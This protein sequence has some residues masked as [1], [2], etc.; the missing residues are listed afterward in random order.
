M[1][2]S[3]HIQA[4]VD[5]QLA[6]M[7]DGARRDALTR[8]LVPPHAQERA[9][10][11]GAP[12]ERYPYW[13]VAE[14]PERG[15]ILVYSDRGFGPEMPWGFL[16]TD[17]PDFAT[18]GMDSQWGWYLEEAFVNSGLWEGETGV[19]EAYHLSPQDRFPP[20]PTRRELLARHA[21]AIGTPRLW[22]LV[23]V[24]WT[25]VALGIWMRITGWRN[26]DWAIGFVILCAVMLSAQLAL[27]R[28]H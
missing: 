8:L 28:R 11:Y 26:G 7:T 10:D 14:A 20:P 18:L 22:L 25:F 19:D 16:F 13:V 1:A 9:W 5:A 27:V 17:A 3:A 23:I 21:W 4:L 12:G 6:L 2:D 24:S 15:M